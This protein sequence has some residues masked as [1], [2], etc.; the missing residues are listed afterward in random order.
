MVKLL[1]HPAFLL[2]PIVH[3]QDARLFLALEAAPRERFSRKG[4]D[5]P[6]GFVSLVSLRKTVSEKSL[7]NLRPWMPGQSG[8]PAGR[9][10][11]KSI[12][13][14]YE[15]ALQ[16]LVPGGVRQALDLPRGATWA[17]LLAQV[18]LRLAAKGTRT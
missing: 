16:Q 13:L 17:T 8:N 1:W 10:R 11:K 12:V 9:P 6:P 14:E 5:T 18:T 15:R 3:W 2:A 7:A 4:V